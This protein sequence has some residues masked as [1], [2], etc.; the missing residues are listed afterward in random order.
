LGHREVEPGENWALQIGKALEQS[1]AM[2]VFVSPKSVKSSHVQNEVEYALT[3]PRYEGRLVVVEIKPTEGVP[4]IL[5]K[6]RSIRLY[7]NPAKAKRDIVSRVR[8]LARATRNGKS[9]HLT[10]A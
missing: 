2:I 5:R 4:W 1:S 8:H 3:S 9:R 10:P 6:F 7:E